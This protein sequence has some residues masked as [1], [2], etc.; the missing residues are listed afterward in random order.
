MIF[1]PSSC[2]SYSHYR[3]TIIGDQ[4]E[5]SASHVQIVKDIETKEMTELCSWADAALGLNTEYNILILSNRKLQ[6]FKKN[7][8]WPFEN[9]KLLYYKVLAYNV[10][11]HKQIFNVTVISKMIFYYL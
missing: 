6:Y 7:K 3:G 1:V 5:T 2:E 9:I 8:W 11:V 4:V 10:C